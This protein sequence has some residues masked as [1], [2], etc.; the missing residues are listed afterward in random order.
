LLQ[1]GLPL[2]SLLASLAVGQPPA[3]QLEAA[4]SEARL[5][6]AVLLQ[7]G[8]SLIPALASFAFEH[9]PAEQEPADVSDVL[10]QHGLSLDSRLARVAFPPFENGQHPGE[11]LAVACVCLAFEQQLGAAGFRASDALSE[12]AADWL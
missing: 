5:A 9:P 10:L 2:F 8:L 7:H 6:S 12:S 3:E 1:Q 11:S 4:P